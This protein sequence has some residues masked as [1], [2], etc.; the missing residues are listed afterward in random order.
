MSF[1]G[2]LGLSEITAG[3]VQEYRVERIK[4]TYNGKPPS[5]STL[6]DEIVTLGLVLKAAIRHGRLNHLPDFS[7]PYK[8]SRKVAHRAWFLPEE[9]R[10]LYRATR[11]NAR[12]AEGGRLV[13]TEG[14]YHAQIR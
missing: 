2:R 1:F 5:S 10:Q 9:Y 12:K 8:A 4:K 13:A 6:H 14:S 11:E 3:K 7:A